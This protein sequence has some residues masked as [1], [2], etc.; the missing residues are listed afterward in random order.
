MTIVRCYECGAILG[1]VETLHEECFFVDTKH[2]CSKPTNRQ[3]VRRIY[4]VV[5]E[6]MDTQ[7]AIKA[8]LESDGR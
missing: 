1:I 3:E 6:S 7:K 2:E 4:E 5:K 8:R